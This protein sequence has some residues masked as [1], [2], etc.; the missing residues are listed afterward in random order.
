M[1]LFTVYTLCYMTDA[2]NYERILDSVIYIYL[3]YSVC[4]W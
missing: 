2:E 4:N 3:P 1:K